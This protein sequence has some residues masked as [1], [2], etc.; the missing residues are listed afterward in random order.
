MAVPTVMT[1]LSWAMQHNQNKSVSCCVTQGCHWQYRH[2]HYFTKELCSHEQGFHQ[3]LPSNVSFTVAVTVVLTA[4]TWPSWAMQ[5]N[6]KKSVSCCVTQGSQGQYKHW[7]YF[8]KRGFS[9]WKSLQ[10]KCPKMCPSQWQWPYL[11]HYLSWLVW[12]IWHI[13]KESY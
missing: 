10:K 6:Q 5:H 8:S 3:N 4:M 1:W 11:I 2:L 9:H 12:A 7:Y 13:K